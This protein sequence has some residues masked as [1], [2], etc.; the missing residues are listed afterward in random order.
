MNRDLEI[1]IQA[2]RKGVEVVKE[3]I[4]TD[5]EIHEKGRNDIVTDADIA[6]EK[7]ILSFLKSEF[8]DD[9]FLAEETMNKQVL[10]KRRVWI[11]DP[12]D[13]TTNFAYRFPIF[14]VSVG[15]WENGEPKAAAIIEV[16]RNEEFTALAGE[17]AYLNG[18]PISVSGRSSYTEA[19]LGTG[20]P[21]NDLSL[22]DDY[23]RLFYELTKQVKGIRRPGAATYDLCCV[24]D[25]RF[26]GFYEYALKAWDVGA[27]ALVVR[28]AG[29][30]VTDWDGGDD[31]L[32]G[33]RIIAGNPHIHQYLLEMIQKHIGQNG[34]QTL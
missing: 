11:V 10:D 12:I 29:G 18:S 34:L 8:P 2:A 27:A 1:A 22:V 3:Y 4:D 13:G 6:S 19:L 23:I 28:E 31:W 26:D 33:Q 20:F 17:G 21:Y 7:V 25:G 16:N 5:F 30:V 32:I 14:C 15:L 24:A 9:Q